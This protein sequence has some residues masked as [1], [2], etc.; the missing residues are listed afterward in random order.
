MTTTILLKSDS[1]KKFMGFYF[2]ENW[3]E[4]FRQGKKLSKAIKKVGLSKEIQIELSSGVYVFGIGLYPERIPNKFCNLIVPKKEGS[5]KDYGIT[6]LNSDDN[7]IFAVPTTLKTIDQVLENCPKKFDDGNS[8][9]ILKVMTNHPELFDV[10]ENVPL[11][12]PYEKC[13]DTASWIVQYED[14]KNNSIKSS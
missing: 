14:M 8:G 4:L 9:I 1:G 5:F 6:S 7:A 3:I 13:F 2:S 10:I 12:K 11:N